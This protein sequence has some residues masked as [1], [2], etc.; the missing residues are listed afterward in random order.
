[1]PQQLNKDNDLK[2]QRTKTPAPISRLQ[3]QGFVL[4]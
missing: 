2:V 1:M 3:K 4:L